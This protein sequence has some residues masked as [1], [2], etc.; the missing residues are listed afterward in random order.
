MNI[1]TMSYFDFLKKNKRNNNALFRSKEKKRNDNA[2][3]RCD[4][5]DTE[6][7]SYFVFKKKQEN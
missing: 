4:L 3:V 2:F 5:I 6:T 1:Q 7:I